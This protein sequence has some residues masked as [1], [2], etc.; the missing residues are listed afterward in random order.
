MYQN[1]VVPTPEEI[2]QSVPQRRVLGM[3]WTDDAPLKDGHYIGPPEEK[4]RYILQTVQYKTGPLIGQV[5][6]REE[7]VS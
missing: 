3:N 4:M 5:E 7:V 1:F 2:W 6:I